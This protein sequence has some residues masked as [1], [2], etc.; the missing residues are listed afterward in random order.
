MGLGIIVQIAGDG[1]IPRALRCGPALQWQRPTCWY[2]ACAVRRGRRSSKDI[3][4]LAVVVFLGIYFPL[5]YCGGI[6]AMIAA[7]E[8]AKPGFTALPA[9]RESTWR[10][11]STP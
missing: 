1:T 10:F 7:I 8:Q 2:P 4:I 9:H 11:S 3:V 6:G 5:D